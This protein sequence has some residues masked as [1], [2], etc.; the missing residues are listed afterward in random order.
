MAKPTD[1]NPAVQ[2]SYAIRTKDTLDITLGG[3]AD[4]TWNSFW[5]A[6]YEKATAGLQRQGDLLVARG[7]IT[8]DE[9]RYLVDVQRNGLV[10]DMRNP[11]T[12]FGKYYSEFL[13]PLK[14]MPNLDKLL[15]QKGTLEAVLRS[16]G[17]SRVAVNRITFI[18]RRAGPAAIAIDIVMTVV[19]IDL[20]PPAQR[21]KV[22]AQ[23]VGGMA[24]SVVAARYGGL[25]GAWAGA[26]LFLLLGS[27]ALAIPVV[28]EITEGGAMMAGSVFG[29]FAGG[30]FG[31]KT[32]QAA[33]GLI[34]Q[35][36]PITWKNY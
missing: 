16:V 26:E 3:V 33:G 14:E 24:G 32:G 18:A 34:W 36:A 25:G 30:L 20:T 4:Y 29:F 27:P 10:R 7:N 1:Q 28:G 8:M 13:K 12:P 17:K 2:Y 9:A 22:A 31:W 5:R 15:A 35:L 23:Q 19:V 11:L 6:A 21:G